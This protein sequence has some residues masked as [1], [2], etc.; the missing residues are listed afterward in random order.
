MTKYMMTVFKV[1]GR[2]D[3]HVGLGKEDVIAE[4]MAQIEHLLKGRIVGVYVG[5]ERTKSMEES[6]RQVLEVAV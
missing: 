4:S 5:I 6:D 1:G 2:I 3:K